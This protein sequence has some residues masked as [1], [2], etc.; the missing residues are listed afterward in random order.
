[1][2]R[3]PQQ[4]AREALAEAALELFYR[5]GVASTSLAEIAGAAGVPTGNVYYH[6]RTKDALVEAV[7][8]PAH[9]L[10]DTTGCVSFPYLHKA[11]IDRAT[12]LKVLL[13][14]KTYRDKG[15][16]EAARSIEINM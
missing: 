15:T 1:M 16:R 11:E 5:Q 7:Y 4:P 13:A 10:P 6:F 2:S 14:G 12:L 9:S 3:V 8:R